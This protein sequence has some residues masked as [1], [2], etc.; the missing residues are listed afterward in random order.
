[1]LKRATR[2]FI[3]VGTWD[4]MA[5]DGY[6]VEATAIVVITMVNGDERE[7]KENSGV[8]MDTTGDLNLTLKVSY[9]LQI[10]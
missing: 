2:D 5:D 4:F 8:L 6:N 9:S 1:M 7:R 10:L 3:M